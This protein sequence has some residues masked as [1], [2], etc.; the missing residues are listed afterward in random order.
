DK[1]TLQ[2]FSTPDSSKYDKV[3]P[4]TM[5]T[6]SVHFGLVKVEDEIQTL[7]QVLVAKEKYAADIRRQLGLSPLANIKQN[8]SKGWQDVQTSSPYL[9]TKESFTYVGHVTSTAMSNVGEAI[10]RRLAEMR[11]HKLPGDFLNVF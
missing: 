8:L 4:K 9:R 5:H 2:G 10:T 11:Y 7:Q 6:M 1:W 3:I